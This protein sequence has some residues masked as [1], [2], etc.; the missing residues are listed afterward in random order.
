[1]AIW[2]TKRVV[3]AN[4]KTTEEKG[5]IFS[6]VSMSNSGSTTCVSKED[7]FGL[8]KRDTCVPTP[9]TIVKNS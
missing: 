7:V 3:D 4:G 8:T 1:M 2:E 9:S 5:G 6:R